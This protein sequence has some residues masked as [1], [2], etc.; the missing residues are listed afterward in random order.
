MPTY[1]GTV[2]RTLGDGNSVPARPCRLEFNEESL[3][4]IP[5]AGPP[6]SLDLGDIDEFAPADFEL[7]L[8]L[9]TGEKL[10]LARFGK[11]FQDLLRELQE[12]YRKRLVQCL[13]LEDLEE[14]ARFEGSARLES[15]AG[16]FS[17][18]AEIRLYQSNLAVLPQSHASFQWRLAD[19]EAMSFDDSNYAIVLRSGD[20]VL[21]LTR[22]A[23]R[24]Q[25]FYDRLQ[26][27]MAEV[28]GRSALTV[29][30]VFPFLTPEQFQRV[31][32]LMKDGHVTA[33]SKL[34]S[35]HPGTGRAL[36]E[37]IVSSRL[38]SYHE[39]LTSRA[40]SCGPYAGFKLIRKD[41]E[42]DSAGEEEIFEEAETTGPAFAAALPDGMIVPP[43]GEDSGESEAEVLH[44]F[45]FPLSTHGAA[46]MPRV[47]AWEA[48]SRTG[49][50]T[51]FFRLIPPGEVPASGDPAE[52]AADIDEAIRRLNRSLL[53]LN[54]RREPIYLS[55]DALQMQLRYR[56]YAIACR[57]IPS[58][59]QLR[60]SFLGRVIHTSPQAWQQQVE[61]L[62]AAMNHATEAS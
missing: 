12:A 43:G 45:L 46:G 47:A 28:A 3:T 18:A 24:T 41:A 17:A 6:L 22:L 26:A 61:R 38:K 27:A 50:A 33:T 4:L 25:E 30:S 60:S 57:K 44:W 59:R 34:A 58:L 11:S 5:T 40:A 37:K 62:L 36:A 56:R 2:A 19:I 32:E 48:T 35:I 39:F 14:I 54:F 23:K 53:L 8:T 49:R 31:A 42:P 20:E 1:S 13:L 51:Y 7:H 29:R 15:A 10:A 21:S 16:G 52:H 9:Y 55:D